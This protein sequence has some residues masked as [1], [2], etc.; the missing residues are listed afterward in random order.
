MKTDDIFSQIQNI[1]ESNNK[2]WMD[3]VKLCF[4]IAPNN[5]KIIMRKIVE[6]DEKIKDLCK[7]LIE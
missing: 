1:R 2:N 4:K 7:K 3:L 6:C 5:A